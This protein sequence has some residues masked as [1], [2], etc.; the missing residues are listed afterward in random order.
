MFCFAK[1]LDQA[2]PHL[3]SGLF[4]EFRCR[5]FSSSPHVFLTIPPEKSINL[6]VY[7]QWVI[8]RSCE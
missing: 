6:D 8:L 4:G 5:D 2:I 3:Q 1:E 7:N